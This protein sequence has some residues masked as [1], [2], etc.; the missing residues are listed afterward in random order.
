MTITQDI[1]SLFANGTRLD[2]AQIHAKLPQYSPRQISSAVLSVNGCGRRRKALR[3]VDYRLY[4]TR[5]A[6]AVFALGAGPDLRYRDWIAEKLD[7]KI[8]TLFSDT[9][10]FTEDQIKHR[11]PPVMRRHVKSAVERLRGKTGGKRKIRVIGYRVSRS[12]IGPSAPIFAPGMQRDVHRHG[13]TEHGDALFLGADATR[14]L[15]QARN[16]FEQRQLARE[17]DHYGR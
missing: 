9:E 4:G 13:G 8:L 11:V 10:G 14:R 5:R 16:R 6:A 12:G 1:L 7:A 15:H 17:L 3:I 2:R